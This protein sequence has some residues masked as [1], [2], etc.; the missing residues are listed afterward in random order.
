MTKED[1]LHLYQ[2]EEGWI[3]IHNGVRFHFANPGPGEI[4]AEGVAHSLSQLCR[5]NGHTKRFY[6]VA[7]HACLMSDWGW[8]HGYTARECLTLLHHDDAEFIIG[9]LPRPIKQTLPEFKAA[10]T[11]LD[12][13]VSKV[14]LTIWPFP[15]WLK[16]IDTRILK[17]ERRAVMDPSPHE[18]GVDGQKALD[19]RFWTV[20][21]RWPWL[22]K[23]RFLERHH[24]LTDL[25]MEQEGYQLT[26]FGP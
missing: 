4:T 11:V 18:W 19:I 14:F 21:G 26:E 16:D 7:E 6:S 10:E 25:M 23:R 5:Y 20:A 17:D 1:G 13:A 2:V 12:E 15:Y 22:V 24:R 8:K 3:E 9:D